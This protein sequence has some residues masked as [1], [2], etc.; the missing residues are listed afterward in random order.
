[1]LNNEGLLKRKVEVEEEA[2]KQRLLQ[3]A[4]GEDHKRSLWKAERTFDKAMQEEEEAARNAEEH[5]ARLT[6]NKGHANQ[7]KKISRNHQRQ[8]L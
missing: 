4:E 1:M 2:W 6:E 3:A 7:R 8:C 5:R